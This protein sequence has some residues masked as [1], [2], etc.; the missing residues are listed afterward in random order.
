MLSMADERSASAAMAAPSPTPQQNV[1][2]QP[3]SAIEELLNL[4]HGIPRQFIERAA[5]Q[6]LP[7][8]GREVD[9]QFRQFVLGRWREH[10]Q[11][12]T[13]QTSAFEISTPLPF[14]KDW[15]PSQ[16]ALDILSQAG[17]DI[18]FAES[19]RAEFILYWSERGGPPRGSEFPLRRT[20]QTA[21]AETHQ[22]N[23]PQYRTHPHCP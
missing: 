4:N 21:L 17:I 12:Q 13:P 2:W 5:A 15:V 16:D 20:C 14:G 18:V 7:A 6:F 22:P 3:S 1:T 9:T 23:A 8:E 11:S 10:Q 19:V